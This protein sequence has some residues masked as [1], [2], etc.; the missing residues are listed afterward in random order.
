MATKT[1]EFC[2]GS[3]QAPRWELSNPFA[4]GTA[5]HQRVR[6]GVC[7]RCD[8]I[9]AVKADGSLRS[10]GRMLSIVSAEVAR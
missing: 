9:I 10:H 3:G 4:V 1:M 8:K 5:L 2:F 6:R 7:V